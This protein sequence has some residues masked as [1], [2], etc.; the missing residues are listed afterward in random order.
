[1]DQEEVSLTLGCN[2][3]A[4][5]PYSDKAWQELEDKEGYSA[6]V[7]W[8]VWQD[9]KKFTDGNAWLNGWAN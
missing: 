5:V 7:V 8:N 9:V 1:M 2:D 6:A 4:W 3:S